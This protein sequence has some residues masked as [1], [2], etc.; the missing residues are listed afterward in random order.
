[1]GRLDLPD[2]NEVD[3]GKRYDIYVAE[4][5]ARIVVYRNAFFRG[6]KLLGEHGR[7]DLRAEFVEIEQSNGQTVF[8]RRYSIVKFCDVGTALVDEK[9]ADTPT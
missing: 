3:I 6:M 7:F 5:P 9:L 2:S 8:V 1:M 4:T